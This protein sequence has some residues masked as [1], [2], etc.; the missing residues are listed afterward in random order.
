MRSFHQRQLGGDSHKKSL[1]LIIQDCTY[2]YAD[3]A[4]AF[5]DFKVS[6]GQSVPCL[7]GLHFEGK[8]HGA[9]VAAAVVL[10]QEMFS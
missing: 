5:D 4:V 2:S 10:G 6:F 3:A 9:T 7:Q 8:L 1:A